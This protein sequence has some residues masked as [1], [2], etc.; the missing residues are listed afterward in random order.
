[1]SFLV[2]TRDTKHSQVAEVVGGALLH[3][4]ELH[5]KTSAL[6]DAVATLD[7]LDR[8]SA[9]LSL[10]KDLLETAS[11]LRQRLATQLVDERAQPTG[12]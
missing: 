7:E 4:A 11:Q 10:P 8:L 6:P 12:G 5:S 1:M 9:R 2:F 3:L